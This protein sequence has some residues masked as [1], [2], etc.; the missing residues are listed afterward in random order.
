MKKL[1]TPKKKFKIIS[2]EF[3]KA[4]EHK[5]SVIL[6]SKDFAISMEEFFIEY[7]GGNK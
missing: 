7:V 4:N 6:N 5:I 1:L 3:F 2:N